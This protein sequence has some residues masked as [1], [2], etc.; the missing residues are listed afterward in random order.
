MHPCE[1]K[2]RKVMEEEGR[3]NFFH[4]VKKISRERLRVADE[5]RPRERKYKAAEY[6]R[7]YYSQ[8][9]ICPWCRDAM[10]LPKHFPGG[11]EMD[12]IDPNLTGE[13]F[14]APWNRQVL[15]GKGGTRNC[16]AEK[17]A[18]N[19][20]EQSKATG[21]TVVDLISGGRNEEHR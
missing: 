2:L 7:L 14:D 20:D 4:Y 16:N 9:G 11:L 18:K 21:R 6:K 12:H 17:N 10:V 15:H 3:S 1:A 8:R 13:A 19:L 5:D